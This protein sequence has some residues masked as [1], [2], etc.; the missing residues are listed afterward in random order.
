MAARVNPGPNRGCRVGRSVTRAAIPTRCRCSANAVHRDSDFDRG[1]LIGK[2]H[3]PVA[4]AGDM[5][6]RPRLCRSH[7]RAES[8]RDR[9]AIEPPV[10]FTVSAGRRGFRILGDFGRG[11]E[12]P[13]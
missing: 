3:L 2:A 13:P 10:P 11:S 12:A 5:K 8:A 6:E 4:F 7:R 9:I 1:H